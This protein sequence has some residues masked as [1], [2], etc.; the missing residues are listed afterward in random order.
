MNNQLILLE[1]VESFCQDI[2][3]QNTIFD[4]DNLVNPVLSTGNNPVNPVVPNVV[5]PESITLY[6]CASIKLRAAIVHSI[7]ILMTEHNFTLPQN[8]TYEQLAD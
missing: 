7:R 2:S 3:K 6:H 5:N 4:Q 8:W 1:T